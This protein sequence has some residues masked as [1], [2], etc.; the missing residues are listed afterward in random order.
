MVV[1]KL[2]T[3]RVKVATMVPPGSLIGWLGLRCRHVI[4]CNHWVLPQISRSQVELVPGLRIRRPQVERQRNPPLED[5]NPAP[6]DRD[7]TSIWP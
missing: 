4:G 7:F 1:H 6:D 3:E 2:E 5:S